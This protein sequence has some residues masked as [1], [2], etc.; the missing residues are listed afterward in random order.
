MEEQLAQPFVTNH[1]SSHSRGRQH[2]FSG[3][4]AHAILEPTVESASSLTEARKKK[5]CPGCQVDYNL[6]SCP[7]FNGGE[8]KS[9]IPEK[10]W[11]SF[12]CL[13]TALLFLIPATKST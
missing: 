8:K 7:H 11:I 13:K 3:G 10:Y 1:S 4:T 5:I 6:D 9:G 12:R 2:S